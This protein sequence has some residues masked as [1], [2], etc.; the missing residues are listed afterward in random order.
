MRY[1]GSEEEELP[2]I[3]ENCADLEEESCD[4]VTDPVNGHHQPSEGS[5]PR[6]LESSPQNNSE[7]NQPK[8]PQC[9]PQDN[10]EGNQ[11]RNPQCS[12]QNN[13][14]GIQPMQQQFYAEQGRELSGKKLQGLSQK[15]IK[16][17]PMRKPK[18]SPGDNIES[19]N[20][21][22]MKYAPENSVEGVNMDGAAGDDSSDLNTELSQ[23]LRY[24][25]MELN[26]DQAAIN[27]LI[28]SGIANDTEIDGYGLGS[29]IHQSGEQQPVIHGPTTPLVSR[30]AISTRL[31][32]CPE[33]E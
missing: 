4:N 33:D 1:V 18:S 8:N 5:Q 28:D 19:D 25:E 31:L 24:D 10:S 13:S 7:G 9:S 23:N 29:I 22:T 27:P 20:L 3:H 14:A 21:E 32:D 15:K 17:D 2:E 12:P 30:V 26:G 11:P 16:G 6:N